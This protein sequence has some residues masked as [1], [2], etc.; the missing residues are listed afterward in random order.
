MRAAVRQTQHVVKKS[1]L[2]V[3][4][5]GV[6]A[7]VDGR[8]GNRNE[9][10]DELGCHVGVGVVVQGQ[11][12]GDFQHVEAKERHPG[13]S[14]GLFE[15][16]SGGQGRTAV[17]Y[18]DVVEA[19]EAPFERVLAGPVLAVDPPGEVEQQLLEAGLKPADIALAVAEF[20]EAV[21]EDRRPG[22]YGRI[23]VAEI[24]LVRRDLAVRVQ[25]AF[26]QHETEL[27]LAEIGIDEGQGQHV[28]GKVPGRVPRVF[29]LV[30]HRDHIGVV[31]VMPLGVAGWLGAGD[32]VRRV[33]ALF[34]PARDVEVEEL[35]A[36]Q[37]AGE[38]LT[39]HLGG[40]G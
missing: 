17:E 6:A 39:H 9:V 18:A 37:H 40:V 5:A 21:G 31:H 1:V 26:A 20:V 12:D 15:I 7:G 28:E 35:L 10:G 16:A 14:V 36:P 3:P 34:Q 19:E 38:R 24:P 22:V 30:G 2:F 32:A 8:G 25:V 23:D 33:A 11:F 4:H 13:R 29:P 27:L